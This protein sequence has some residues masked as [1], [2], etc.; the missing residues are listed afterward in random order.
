MFE[1]G[2]IECLVRLSEADK[3]TTV[4]GYLVCTYVLSSD[5]RWALGEAKVEQRGL[6]PGAFVPG[7]VP[8]VGRLGLP[9][10]PQGRFYPLKSDGVRAKEPWSRSK[11]PQ[12]SVPSSM[13]CA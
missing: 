13:P 4:H 2:G 5:T 9:S 6:G 1:A 12:V 11:S 3:P 7:F 10:T 8:S